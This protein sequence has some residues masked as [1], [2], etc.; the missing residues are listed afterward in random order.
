MTPAMGM[1]TA[2][3]NDPKDG[4][5]MYIFQTRNRRP[6]GCRQHWDGL[7]LD[8]PEHVVLLRISSSKTCHEA[9]KRSRFYENPEI[10][11]D[12]LMRMHAKPA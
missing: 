1:V 9:Y 7:G 12:S 8:L 11:K 5:T 4:I 6:Q 2:I 3:S 10:F